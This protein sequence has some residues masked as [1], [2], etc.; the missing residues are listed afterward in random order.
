MQV[1][2]PLIFPLLAIFSF[3]TLQGLPHE[4]HHNFPLVITCVAMTGFLT[5]NGIVSVRYPGQL[6]TV[7]QA[8]VIA[9]VKAIAIFF[10]ATPK[11][12]F[13]LNN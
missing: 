13:L 8:A 11:L 3:W 9:I 6:A 12:L 5:Q 4:S 7:G 1:N 10:I 2:L